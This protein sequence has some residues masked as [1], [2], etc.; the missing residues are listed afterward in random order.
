MLTEGCVR[1]LENFTKCP[2]TQSLLQHLQKNETLIALDA[3]IIKMQ[4]I[5]RYA[6]YSDLRASGLSHAEAQGIVWPEASS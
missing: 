3:A 2:P 1:R 6:E 4:I 5:A